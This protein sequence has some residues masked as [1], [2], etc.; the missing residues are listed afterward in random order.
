MMHITQSRFFAAESG[1]DSSTPTT[2][3]KTKFQ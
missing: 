3:G 1:A 2:K